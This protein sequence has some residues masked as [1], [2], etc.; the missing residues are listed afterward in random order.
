M[1][2]KN[3]KYMSIG[4]LNG[5]KSIDYFV[6]EAFDFSTAGDRGI[7]E[8]AGRVYKFIKYIQRIFSKRH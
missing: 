7:Q 4:N 5:K 8:S 6:E 2:A 3:L 1:M